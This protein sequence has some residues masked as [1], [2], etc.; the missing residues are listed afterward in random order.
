MATQPE[1]FKIPLLASAARTADITT[2]I[3]KPP[4]DATGILVHLD[5]TALVTTFSVTP[6]IQLVNPNDDTEFDAYFAFTAITTL[7]RNLLYLKPQTM[8]GTALA[9]VEIVELPLP[10]V[11]NIFFNHADANS[12]TYQVRAQ[13]I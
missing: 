13:F 12:V 8:G 10:P 11:F 5:F 1:V 4:P 9:R 2:A 3:M 6:T 7:G